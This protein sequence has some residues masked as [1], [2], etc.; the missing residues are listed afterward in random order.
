MNF[1]RPPAYRLLRAP[2]RSSPVG[3]RRR[4]GAV[5]VTMDPAVPPATTYVGRA[6]EEYYQL[7]YERGRRE[8]R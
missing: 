7:G 2:L 1:P 6:A 5:V 3:G 4:E 8:G